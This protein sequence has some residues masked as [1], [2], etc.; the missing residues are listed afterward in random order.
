MTRDI[1]PGNQQELGKIMKTPTIT[2]AALLTT[3]TAGHCEQLIVNSYGGP[4]EAIIMERIIKPFEDKTGISVVYDPVGSS[5]QDYAKIKAT[6]GRPGFDV[7]VMTASQSL[8]GCRDGLLEKFTPATVPNLE[9]LSPAINKIAGECGAVHELQ[10]MS[11]LWRTDKL[12]AAPS[13]WVALFDSELKG[14]VILPTFQ[15]IMAANLM[16][17]LSVQNGGDLLNNVDPGFK[18]MAQLA[19]Q[20]VGFEQSSAVMETYVKDGQVWAMP[21]WNGRAQLLVDTGM[22][23]DYIKPVEGTIPLIATLNVPVGTQ[24]KE[25]AMKFV[26][27][28]LEKSSQEAWVTGYKVGSARSDIDVPDAVRAKQ[29]TTEEDLDKLLL[30]DLSIMAAKLPEWGDRWERE[31]VHAAN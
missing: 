7:V 18:A 14:K 27:F 1:H 15:N 24:N 25:A 13:S 9:K 29:I 28:F 5:S 2:A 12:K 31:V 30:P 8:D 11:L 23:V 22:P 16:Q 17:V 26:N 6:N 21:F 3:V 19:K 20:S 10:Y 4:Y